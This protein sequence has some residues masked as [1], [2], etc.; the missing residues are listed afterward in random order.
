MIMDDQEEVGKNEEVE[1]K[2]NSQSSSS[3][4]QEIAQK[5]MKR[6]KKSAKKRSGETNSTSCIRTNLILGICYNSYNNSC[7]RYSNVFS[8]YARNGNG[9]NKSSV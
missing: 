5:I 3:K 1:K 4:I 7:N 6:L 2:G 8:N 9:E